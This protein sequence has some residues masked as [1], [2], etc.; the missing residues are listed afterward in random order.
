MADAYTWSPEY[1]A[2]QN[3]AFTEAMEEAGYSRP[4]F[5]PQIRKISHPWDLKLSTAFK[6]EFPWAWPLA[7]DPYSR[8][9]SMAAIVKEV[10]KKHGVSPRQIRGYGRT[11]KVVQARQEAFWRCRN[12]GSIERSY[13]QI[14]KYFGG[15]D[16]TTVIHGCNRFQERML[17]RGML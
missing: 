1:L 8:D 12:Q 4:V 14:G 13:P 10:A 16:H 3:A 6:V 2:E 5:K 15:R 11:R 17:D 7:P 9:R